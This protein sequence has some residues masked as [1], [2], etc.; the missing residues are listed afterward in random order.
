MAR[1]RQWQQLKNCNNGS[2]EALTGKQMQQQRQAA[3]V[4]ERRNRSNGRAREL[5][6]VGQTAQGFEEQQLGAPTCKEKGGEQQ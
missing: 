3:A 1:E 6:T 2:G 5:K 4:D